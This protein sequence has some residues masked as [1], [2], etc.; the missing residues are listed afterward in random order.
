MRH[1]RRVGI[2]Q[3]NQAGGLLSLPGRLGHP[4]WTPSPQGPWPPHPHCTCQG[5]DTSAG[6]PHGPRGEQLDTGR[7]AACRC[8]VSSTLGGQGGGQVSCWASRTENAP[9]QGHRSGEPRG[10]AL[11]DPWAGSPLSR[12]EWSFVAVAPGL[13]EAPGSMPFITQKRAWGIP[14]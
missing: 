8:A 6:C 5:G 2:K 4:T 13:H 14:L 11:R 10:Q 12:R 1:T 9:L 7:G 3:K